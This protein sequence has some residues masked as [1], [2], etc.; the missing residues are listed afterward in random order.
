MGKSFRGEVIKDDL[1]LAQLV[2]EHKL[3]A[4]VPGSP[5][6]A[7]G[8]VRMSYACSMDDIEQGVARLQE[9]VAELS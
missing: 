4:L 7:P 3:V 1:H 8:F 9:F 5:F 6:G 2:L